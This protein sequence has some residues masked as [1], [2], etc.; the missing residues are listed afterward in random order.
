MTSIVVGN[1]IDRPFT[2]LACQRGEQQSKICI[3]QVNNIIICY[4]YFRGKE[5]L[6]CVD[7]LTILFNSLCYNLHIVKFFSKYLNILLLEK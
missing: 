7:R 5:T 1:G 3:V 4:T 6:I 2:K